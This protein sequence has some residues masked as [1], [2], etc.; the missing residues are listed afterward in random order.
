MARIRSPKSFSDHFGIPS[1]KLARLGVLDP[2][3][4]VDT[5]LFIDPL[6]LAKSRHSEI[7]KGARPTY[8]QHFTKVIKFLRATKGTGDVAWR[9]TQRLLS[10][11]EIK[12]T[13]L[14]Y[15]AQSVSGSGSGN[16]MTGQFIDT[17]RQIVQ[18]GVDDPDLFAAMALFEEGVGPDRISDMTTN[19]I[20]GDLLQFNARVLKGLNIPVQAVNLPLRN[21]KIFDAALPINPFIRGG[22]PVVLLP[23]DILRDLPIVTDWSDVADAASKNEQLRNQVNQQIAKLWEVK[24][25]KNKRQLRKWAMSGSDQFET[26]LDMIR[27]ADARPYDTESDP[28]GELVWRRIA[29]TLASDA[30]FTIKQPALLDTAGVATVVEQIIEQFRFLIEDRRLSKELYHAGEP[31]PER[32]AQRLFFAVAHAYCKANNLDLTPEADTGNG[33]VDF[34][35]SNGY[36]GRVLVEIKLSRNSK[37]VAGYTRQ[38]ETYK[39]AEETVKGYYLVIDVGLMGKKAQLLLQ[40]KN[41]AALKGNPVSPIVFVNGLQKPSASKL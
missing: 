27:S 8:E 23:N 26:L 33:P 32:A 18:L 10:F 30:P 1:A 40:V 20:F 6:L 22:G 38:L 31:R 16:E 11:P 29:T 15:G 14:G 7:S 21:G 39:K 17:A 35:V 37:L 25:R 3:L 9:S 41:Q 5:R 2:T 19:V 28:L 13:C 36:N 4:N 12:W 34:K 24:S